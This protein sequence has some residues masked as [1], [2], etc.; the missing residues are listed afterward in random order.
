MLGCAE[1]IGES[2]MKLAAPLPENDRRE[3]YLRAV[4]ETAGNGESVV[5]AFARQDSS[6]LSRLAA[7]DV[8][9]VREPHAKPAEAGESV[10]VIHLQASAF[11]I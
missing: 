5:R 6:M 2:R 7:A 10:R 1:T 3:D 8:L 4:V 9:I 11:R